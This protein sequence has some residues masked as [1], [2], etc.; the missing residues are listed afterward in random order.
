MAKKSRRRREYSSSGSSQNMFKGTASMQSTENMPYNVAGPGAHAPSYGN[1]ASNMPGIT[2]P[3]YMDDKNPYA[4][5]GLPQDIPVQDPRFAPGS[6]RPFFPEI[7]TRK[8]VWDFWRTAVALPNPDKVLGQLNENIEAYDEILADG[9]VKAAFNNRRAGL[10]SLKYTIDQNN[11]PSKLYKIVQKSFEQWDISMLMSEMALAT[12]YG[13]VVSEVNWKEDG[14]MILPETMMS[15]APRWFVYSDNNELR[16]KTKMQMVLGEALPPHKFIVTRYHPTYENPYGEALAGACYWPAKFRHILQNYMMQFAE[17]YV[18][19]WI[20][21]TTETGMQEERLRELINVVQS[22]YQNGVIAHPDNTKIT[23]LPIG[24]SKS[25][26]TYLS[27]IDMFNREIDMALLG[28]NLATEVTGGSYAAAQSH[29]GIRQD[30]VDEDRRM[31]ENSF[32]QLISWIAWYNFPAGVELP[33]F[34]LY[35]I[36]PATKEKADTDVILA[37]MGVKFTKD[38]FARIY[39][40]NEEDFEMGEPVQ[41]LNA[42]MQSKVVESGIASKSGASPGLSTADATKVQDATNESNDQTVNTKT[43]AT[44]NKR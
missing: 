43:K 26:E 33:K 2:T 19:P 34:R 42:G 38:Y 15:K 4:L 7:V 36:E 9:R 1:I 6:V 20:D 35:K 29:M 25:A 10:L 21:I 40:L 11:A 41:D 22:T 14:G 31:V 24:D 30:L 27:M 44:G 3:S 37:K 13:Y 8:I 16:I 5:P 12:F 18:M 39:Q 32:N 28:C 23:P 17:R